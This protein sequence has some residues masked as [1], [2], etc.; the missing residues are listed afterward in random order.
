MCA[1]AGAPRCCHFSISKAWISKPNQPPDTI[2]HIEWIAS[3]ENICLSEL[4]FKDIPGLFYEMISLVM[5]CVSN[6]NSFVK[7]LFSDEKKNVQNG[8]ENY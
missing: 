2:Y 3:L 8:S 6:P 5:G 1:A 4:H 7:Y